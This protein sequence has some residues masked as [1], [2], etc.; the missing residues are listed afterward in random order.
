M[1]AQAAPA[2]AAAAEQQGP[3]EDDEEVTD[4]ELDVHTMCIYCGAS[5]A[6]VEQCGGCT[7]YVHRLCAEEAHSQYHVRRHAADDTHVYCED[8]VQSS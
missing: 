8:C 4:A 7:N 6:H 3:E 5:D 1:R 2:A